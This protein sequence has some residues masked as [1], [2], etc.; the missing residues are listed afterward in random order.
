MLFVWPYDGNLHENLGRHAIYC[1]FQTEVIFVFFTK[2]DYTFLTGP[3]LVNS[4]SLLLLNFFV[5]KRSVWDI[6]SQS[7]IFKAKI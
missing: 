6:I 5:Q 7:D 4:V 3:A 1:K 2:L